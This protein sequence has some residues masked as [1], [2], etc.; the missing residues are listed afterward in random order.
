MGLEGFTG[1]ESIL[2]HLQSPCRVKELGAFTPIEREEWVPEAHAHRRMNTFDVPPRGRRDLRPPDAH[3]ERRRRDLALPAGVV[4]GLLLPERRGRRGRLRPRGKRDARDDV[5]RRAVQGGR[6]RRHPARDDVPLRPQRPAALP[7]LRDARPDRDPAALSQPVRADPR[8]RAVL[9]PRHPPA[10]RAQDAPRRGRLP[11][12]GPRAARVPGVRPR[13]PPVRR[14]RAGTAS[15]TR[16]RSR[17]TTSSRSP[18]AS[19]SRRRPTRRSRDRT[20]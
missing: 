17:S 15:S 3:V 10:D 16:G 4:H 8:R 14:R 5:R 1:N 2:Y 13:L 11:R 12:Q 19:T 7:R 18:A 6:L 20:S 9:P